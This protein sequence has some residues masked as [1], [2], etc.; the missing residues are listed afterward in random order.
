MLL[1]L[2]SS[3][4]PVDWELYVAF[5]RREF[6]PAQRDIAQE[7]ALRLAEIV[8]LEIKELHPDC[9]LK[10]LFSGS[11]IHCSRWRLGWPSAKNSVSHVTLILL[12]GRLL[13]ASLLTAKVAGNL[14]FGTD[15]GKR[16]P[17]GPKR[18][19]ILPG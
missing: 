3:S 7:V 12:F 11:M 1:L 14:R 18:S 4:K 6:P 2:R 5:I 13:S 17:E 15:A 16:W 8:G 19:N 10:G 9:T